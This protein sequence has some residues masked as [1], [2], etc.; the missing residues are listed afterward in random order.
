MN[1][2]DLITERYLSLSLSLAINKTQTTWN[3]MVS[4]FSNYV[5]AAK[6]ANDADM[7]Y[8]KLTNRYREIET[9][10]NQL[11]KSKNQPPV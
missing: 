11:A 5:L 10:L 1:Y 7:I 8:T 3:E 2:D 4:S 6:P 9:K